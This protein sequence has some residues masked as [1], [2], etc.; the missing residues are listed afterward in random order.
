MD[1]LSQGLKVMDSTAITLCMEK[2]LP[3]IVFDLFTDGNIARVVS[4]EDLG[5]RIEG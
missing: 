1:V 2:S 5:T 3:V 4:G